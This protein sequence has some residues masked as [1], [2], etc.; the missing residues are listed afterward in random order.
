MNAKEKTAMPEDLLR[1]AAGGV[2]PTNE[3]LQGYIKV[4]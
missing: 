2:D 3:D 4:L 1:N